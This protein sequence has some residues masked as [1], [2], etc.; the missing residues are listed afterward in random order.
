MDNT[1]EGIPDGTTLTAA[2]SAQSGDPIDGIIY[3]NSLA[4][5]ATGNAGIQVTSAAAFRGARGVRITLAAGTSYVRQSH[6][7]PGP[8]A[9]ARRPFKA[10]ST[11]ASNAVLARFTAVGGGPLGD[12]ADATMCSVTHM[13]TGHIALEHPTNG[14][15]MPSRYLIENN[16]TYWIEFAV[17]KGTTTTDGESWLWIY[18]SDGTTLL[19][20]YHATG[21]NSRS[22]DVWR[23]RWG[24]AISSVGWA[25]DDFDD[26]RFDMVPGTGNLGPLANQ[27]PTIPAIAPRTVSAG[28]SVSITAA[29]VDPDGVIGAHAWTVAYSSTGSNPSL[30]GASSPTVTLTAPAAGNLVVLKYVATDTDGQTAETFVEVRVPTTGNVTILKDGA[31]HASTTAWSV[32]GGAA[33]RATALNDGNSATGIESPE[34]GGSTSISRHRLT[35]SVVRDSLNLTLSGVSKS[36]PGTISSL[37]RLMQGNTVLETWDLVPTTTPGNRTLPLGPSTL[38]AIT[39]WGNL[40]LQFEAS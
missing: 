38:S 9:V 24:G 30:S 22:S 3:N 39:D 11:P 25:Y 5:A 21:V 23:V 18:D 31:P 33:D 29:P 34:A 19:W 28:S 26:T 37:V 16:K 6:P 1:Y 35:P 32:F 10:P 20:E 27:P 8:R 40:W 17:Q 13:S 36:D 7:T 4:P 12:G 15:I 14:V 2:V